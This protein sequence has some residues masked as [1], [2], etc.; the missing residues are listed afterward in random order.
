MSHQPV[1]RVRNGSITAHP[2]LTGLGGRGRGRGQANERQRS[3]LPTNRP[4]LQIPATSGL[5]I[6]FGLLSLIDIESMRQVVRDPY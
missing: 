3:E 1:W 5:D 4:E 2:S 6:R